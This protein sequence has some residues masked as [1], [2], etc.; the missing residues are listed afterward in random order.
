MTEQYL[1]SSEL[2]SLIGYHDLSE[3]R[4][5]SQDSYSDS[6]IWKT[7]SSRQATEPLLYCA[8]QTSIV[9]YGNKVF[10]EYE[11][12]GEKID[13]KKV[14]QLYNVK[15]DLNLNSKIQPGDLTPRRLQRFFRKQISD[16]ILG[17][18]NIMPYL[19]KK[20]ST[21]DSKYRHLV[22]PGA[23]NLVKTEDEANYLLQ[24]YMEL[25]SRIDSTISERI[26]R[27]LM[28]RGLLSE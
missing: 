21:M 9:G 4:V 8:I 1:S 17:N 11:S 15:S 5:L 14:Y 12:R 2:E 23:E 26:R 19:W 10:G 16:Y 6:E 20:Y 22:F 7:I 27:I 25:D 13:V 18:K 24:T 28:A 3:F